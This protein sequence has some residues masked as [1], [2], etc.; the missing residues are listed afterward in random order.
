MKTIRVL[1]TMLMLVGGLALLALPPVAHAGISVTLS[2]QVD[3]T[4]CFAKLPASETHTTGTEEFRTAVSE[5][6]MAATQIRALSGC[7]S[8]HMEI[9]TE[10]QRSRTAL[11][12]YVPARAHWPD[13]AS[14][15][16][17]MPR[18][19]TYKPVKASL[20]GLHRVGGQ[21]PD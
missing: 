19:G 1:A 7:E 15:S 3:T 6:V 4:T 14:R 18:L 2:V 8:A 20:G 5:F 21:E 16:G 11:S 12:F 13:M 17:Q 9:A 10:L